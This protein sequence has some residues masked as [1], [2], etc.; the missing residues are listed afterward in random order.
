MPVPA[1]GAVECTSTSLVYPDAAAAEDL[2][3]VTQRCAD[4]VTCLVD[5]LDAARRW[6]A[7]RWV[8]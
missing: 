7:T 1:A 3:T 6:A 2:R 5:H 4:V 8:F